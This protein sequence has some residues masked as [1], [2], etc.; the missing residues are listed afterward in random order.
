MSLTGAFIFAILATLILVV[1]CATPYLIREREPEPVFVSEE[2][3]E[4]RD[5]LTGDEEED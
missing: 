3:S 5:W 2:I 4:I 1:A